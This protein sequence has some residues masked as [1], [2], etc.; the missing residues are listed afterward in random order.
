M[1]QQ[2]NE[3]DEFL[4]GGG[5]MFGPS[6]KFGSIGDMVVGEVLEISMQDQTEFGTDTKIIDPRTGNP[7]R[8]MRVVLQTSLRNWEQV[9]KLPVDQDKNPL[10]ASDDTGTRSIYVKGWMM[11]SVGDAIRAAGETGAPKV[12][13]KLAVKFTE[14]A[15]SGKGNPTKKFAAQYAAP[16]KGNAEADDLLGG[17]TTTA[18]QSAAATP[19]AAPAVQEDPW[20]GATAQKA[21]GPPPF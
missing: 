2:V 8:Q 18:A 6:F 11:G 3:A 14:E 9:A 19:A 10:P 13:G 4:S 1:T 17:S 16:P 12:G 20:A 15:P 21:D 7:K 5:G